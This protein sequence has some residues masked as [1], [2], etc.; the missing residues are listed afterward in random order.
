[1]LLNDSSGNP[2]LTHTMSIV[3]FVIVMFKV[4]FGGVS[5]SIGSSAYSFGSIDSFSIAAILTP[6][7]GAY[8]ARRF[9]D[10]NSD[11]VSDAGGGAHD[12]TA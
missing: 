12:G 5:I 11:P 3:S 7:L 1:M 4:F 8:V 6:T 10:Q 2:S 9:G